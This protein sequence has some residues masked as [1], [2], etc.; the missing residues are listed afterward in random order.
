MPKDKAIELVKNHFRTGHNIDY[1]IESSYAKLN[2][3]RSV[4]NTLNVLRSLRATVDVL[5]EYR[6]YLEV[7]EKIKRL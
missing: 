3:I 1:D 6:F 5:K 4:E 7:K 2:A